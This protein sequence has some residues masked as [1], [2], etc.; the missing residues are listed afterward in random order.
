[1]SVLPLHASAVLPLEKLR[2][3]EIEITQ[4]HRAKKRK[5]RSGL[6]ALI[7]YATPLLWPN[8]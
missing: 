3:A 6:S 1:M 4:Y 7:C 5:D 8:V 2:C